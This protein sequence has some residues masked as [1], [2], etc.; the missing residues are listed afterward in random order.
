[1]LRGLS[2]TGKMLTD[3]EFCRVP[4]RQTCSPEVG[5][6]KTNNNKKNTQQK[7][8]KIISRTNQ[9]FVQRKQKAEADPK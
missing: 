2:A 4:V 7:L 6:T 3:Q 5:E 9:L 8:L 1:M